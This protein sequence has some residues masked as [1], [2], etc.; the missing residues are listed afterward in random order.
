VS[1][2]GTAK[3]CLTVGASESQRPLPATIHIDP[4]MQDADFNA[5]TP[6]VNV[7]LQLPLGVADNPDEIAGFS[8]RGPTNDV[9]DS[10]I[11]PDLVAPGT[12]ILSCRSSVSTADVGPDGL[13]HSSL[14]PG[15]YADDKDNLATHAEAVGR[16]L[17]GAPFFGT[18]N[19]STPDA[20]AGSG[21]IYQQNYFY[22]SGTSMATPSPRARRRCCAS[23]F[24]SG[25]E[26][27]VRPGR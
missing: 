26:W 13:N 27:S 1:P 7:P 17:P 6:K 22:D 21:P 12:F 8:G 5:A 11:K 3:N 2:P 20:P 14:P 16:G 4:N 24:G 9:G 10:R 19:E 18:W 15:F 23:I 25:A